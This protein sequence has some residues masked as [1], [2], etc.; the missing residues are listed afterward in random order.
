MWY[1]KTLT[2]S[3]KSRGFHLVTLVTGISGEGDEARATAELF[4][5]NNKQTALIACVILRIFFPK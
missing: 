3:A 5:A 2:L 4:R 1:Q